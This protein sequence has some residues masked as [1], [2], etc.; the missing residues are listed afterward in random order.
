M[1][2]TVSSLNTPHRSPSFPFSGTLSKLGCPATSA[3]SKLVTE[4]A[5]FARDGENSISQQGL[6]FVRF[7]V[8]PVGGRIPAR[9]QRRSQE[10]QRA[11]RLLLASRTSH[12][13][14]AVICQRTETGGGEEERKREKNKE[15][16]I[17]TTNN[18][19]ETS[20]PYIGRRPP[21]NPGR[22]TSLARGGEADA[23][24]VRNVHGALWV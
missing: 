24:T 3:G 21:R 7:D 23:S 12:S 16:R 15:Q 13:S 22:Y 5:W 19:K 8:P 20:M 11:A 10:H 17:E 18:Q 2:L 14:R 6:P 4:N 9:T 1:L